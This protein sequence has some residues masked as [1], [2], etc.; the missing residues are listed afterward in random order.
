MKTD[1]Y[2]NTIDCLTGKQFAQLANISEKVQPYLPFTEVVF[3]L[4]I[5]TV[6]RFV[7]NRGWCNAESFLRK[8]LATFKSKYYSR[9]FKVN[10]RS[11]TGNQQLE[12][13][14]SFARPR[15][16]EVMKEYEPIEKDTFVMLFR[17]C[18]RYMITGMTKDSEDELIERLWVIVN[19]LN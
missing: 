15:M 13:F 11:L 4:L 1:C 8:D 10:T 2:N 18:K 17:A 16:K 6:C 3:I 19:I 9:G 14:T 7:Y 5:K 12:L